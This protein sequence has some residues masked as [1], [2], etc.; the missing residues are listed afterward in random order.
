MPDDLKQKCEVAWNAS[1]LDKKVRA[2]WMAVHCTTNHPV[3]W[4]T[5]KEFQA[6]GTR[7]G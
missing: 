6:K 2:Q 4:Q 7:C 1:E 3:R 5:L